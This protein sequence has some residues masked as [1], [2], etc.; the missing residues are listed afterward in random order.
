MSDEI[1]NPLYGKFDE[2]VDA[3]V[4]DKPPSPEEAVAGSGEDAIVR[5]KLEGGYEEREGRGEDKEG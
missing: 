3:L 4:Q 1:T 2:V 5:E